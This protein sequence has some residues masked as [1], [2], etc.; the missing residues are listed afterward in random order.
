M[1]EYVLMSEIE[2]I[3]YSGRKHCWTAAKKPT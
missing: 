3:I 2:I 1:L